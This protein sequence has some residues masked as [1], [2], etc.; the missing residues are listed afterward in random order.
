MMSTEP[1][2]VN[3]GCGACLSRRTFLAE[4]TA[5]AVTALLVACGSDGVSA[6]RN[7]NETVRLAEYP[8]LATVGGIARLNGTSTPI[9]VVRTASSYRAFSLICP[10]ESGSVGVSGNGF[11][12]AKHGARFDANGTWTGGERTTNL[13]EFTVRVDAT[14]NTL[15]ITS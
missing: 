3:D 8:T 15:T 10:H 11:Q 9:A 5:L 1:S 12:C 13:N 7:V 2:P 6:P 14:A 4:S